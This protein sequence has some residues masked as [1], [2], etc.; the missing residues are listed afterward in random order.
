MTG[1][2]G[3]VNATGTIT[4]TPDNTAAAP[5]SDPTLCINTALTNITIATT[6][7]T[8][9][10]NA[11]DASGVNGLPIGV[12]ASWA[13]DIIT[14]SGTPSES[15]TFNYSIPMTGGC[16]TVNAT[17]TITVTPLAT[18][19]ATSVAYP[20]VCISSPTLTPFSQSTTGVTGI[21]QDGVAGVNGLPPGISAT[22]S[23]NTIT[24]SGTATTT[25]L[26]TYSIPLTGAC[27]NGLTATG[28]IDVTP[29]YEL[30]SVSS[31]SATVTGGTASITINGALATLPNGLY[32]VTYILDDGIN[33]PTEYTS[34]SFSVANGRGTFSSIPLDDEDVDVY[35]LTIKS[36]KKVTDV[37]TIDLDINDPVNTTYFS[38]C[39]APFNA[40]GTFYVP[41]GIYEIS[42][43]ALGAGASGESE[44][45]T[46]PVTPG[47]PLGIVVGQSGGTGSGRDT[48]VTRDSSDP[49]PISTSLIYVMGGGG[50]GPNGQVNISY[51]CP[52]ANKFDCIEVIDDGAVSGIAVIEFICSTDWIA[53]QGLTEFFVWAGG[54]G[55]GGGRGNAAGGG[56]AGGTN[57]E[58]VIIANPYGLPA[59]TT[60]DIVVGDGG[61]GAETI[62]ERGVNGDTTS[63]S[64]VIDGSTYN[65]SAIGGGGGGSDLD[66]NGGSGGSGG[67]AGA[68]RDGDNTGQGTAGEGSQGMNGGQANVLDKGRQ[69]AIAGGGGGGMTDPRK[70]RE[71][72]GNANGNGTAFGGDGGDS[73]AIN[74]ADN[75]FTFYFGA[76]GGGSGTNFNGA[77]KPGSGGFILS[78][79]SIIG[80]N[81]NTEGIGG[82]GVDKTGS[83]GGAGLLGGGKGGS[84][85]VFITYPVFR[86]LEVEYL[87]FDVKYNSEN[88]TDVLSWAT[89][90]EWENSHFEIERSINGVTDWQKI[91]QVEGQGY[92]ELPTEYSYTDAKLPASGGIVYYRLKQVDFDGSFS[93]SVTK[94]IKIEGMNGHG[95][96]IVYPNPSSKKSTITV[97]LLNRAVYNDES[98]LIQ[99]SDIRGISETFTVNQVEAV[100]EVVNRYMEQSTP[101]VYILQLIWGNNS[102]QLKLLR[103]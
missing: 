29:D 62:E 46:I 92:S 35:K 17:G 66:N 25:G 67:G 51:S 6:G 11:G 48:W 8:G 3:T 103:E 102:Q 33:T 14:I 73:Q 36:I 32:E 38:V 91:G 64:G 23:G 60:F 20:S 87:Y 96:W 10:A 54:G 94:S 34:S 2:C 79:D 98:I 78:L 1:G 12:S 58:Q 26:Y 75:N 77:E 74:L 70:P 45:I 83:G 82:N 49:D 93:Y 30:S 68:F 80:G 42:I 31:A 27:I 56:G 44:T 61:D 41:A 59:G 81:G 76:G 97:D 84:G 99:I 28:T 72:D 24:F 47:E 88:R 71:K 101:G 57:S 65:I 100:S 13:G 63:V 50:T 85:R 43:Q 7:A 69:L 89:S 9:I 55:G 90:N 37:C 95:A 5:S 18:V 52:D 22:F 86:I 15:G 16:G 19:G 53:P 21:N 4:V 40:D 39:G